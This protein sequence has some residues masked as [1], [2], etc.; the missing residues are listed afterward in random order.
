MELSKLTRRSFNKVAAFLQL[1]LSLG[2]LSSGLKE[3][4]AAPVQIKMQNRMKPRLLRQTVEPV[5]SI[6]VS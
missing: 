5:F 3:A 2:A 1:V 6:A 4:K